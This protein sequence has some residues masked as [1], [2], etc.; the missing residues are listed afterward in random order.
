METIWC[1]PLDH[2]RKN[3]SDFIT[4][5]ETTSSAI[6]KIFY[7]AVDEAGN[8]VVGLRLKSWKN[9]TPNDGN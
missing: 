8:I 3:G 1:K 4:Y 9:P 6:D 2:F 5:E 7:L